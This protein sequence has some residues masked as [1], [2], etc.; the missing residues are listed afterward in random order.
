MKDTLNLLP[1]EQ[2]AGRAEKKDKF[3]YIF[4]AFAAYCLVMTVLWLLRVVEIKKF[5]AEISSL[6]K[7]KIE[8]SQKIALPPQI[9][10]TAAVDKNILAL[11]EKNPKWSLMLSDL[12]LVVPENVWLSSLE[13]K[14]EKNSSHVSIKGFST[15]QMGVA[16]LISALEASN[17]F[18]DVEIV[19]AQKGE[20]DVAFELIARLKWT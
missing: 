10:I 5:D 12:S 9:D 8:L 18:Y 6:T 2:K 15:T 17:H 7:Q 1:I 14:E 4:L 16:N 20:K 11:I 13:S 3:F 19:F